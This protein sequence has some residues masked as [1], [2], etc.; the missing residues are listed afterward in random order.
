MQ[1]QST[2]IECIMR[3][4]RKAVMCVSRVIFTLVDGYEAHQVME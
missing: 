2:D 1:K 4:Q 3:V